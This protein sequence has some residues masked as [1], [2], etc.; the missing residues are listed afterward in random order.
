MAK[1]K[2]HKKQAYVYEADDAG[3]DGADFAQQLLASM[4]VD[5]GEPKN[6]VG[7]DAPAKEAD[8][9]EVKHPNLHSIQQ[10]IKNAFS[11]KS[12]KNEPKRDATD[13]PS[14]ADSPKTDVPKTDVPKTDGPNT[15]GPDA[16]GKK[17]RNRRREKLAER[18]RERAR[19][20]QQAEVEAKDVTQQRQV[21]LNSMNSTIAQAGLVEYEVQPDGHCLFHSLSDQLEKR[22]QI[23]VDY[24]HLRSEIANYI[25]QHAEEFGPY[26]LTD[27]NEDPQDIDS[28]TDTLENTPMWGGQLEIMAASGLYSVPVKLFF[29]SQP[30]LTVNEEQFPDV[31]PLTLAYY[32]QKFGLG[33]HYNSLRDKT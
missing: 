1:K 33:A 31:L 13:A 12:T 11:S 30:P 6:K 21:E 26:L 25:R 16:E 5:S 15:D 27:D 20:V 22:R 7:D 14:G 28:Y 24:R 17:K 23:N 18:E 32:Q 2:S 4:S 29:A 8:P 19:V 9:A 10:G 3:D